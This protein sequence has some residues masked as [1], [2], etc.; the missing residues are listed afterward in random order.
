MVENHQFL[1]SSVIFGHQRATIGPMQSKVKSFLKTD[2]VSVYL[3]F[4]VNWV[5][6]F[7]FNGPKPPISAILIFC[8]QKNQTSSTEPK[9]KSVLQT[10]QISLYTKFVMNWVI[11]FSENAQKLLTDNRT[12]ACS[13]LLSPPDSV[14]GDNN[15]VNKMRNWSITFTSYYETQPNRT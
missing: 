6:C 10:H 14:T 2:P 7:P 8:H 4:E 1:M 3:K 15:H 11:N 5:M 12:D 13:L 9:S